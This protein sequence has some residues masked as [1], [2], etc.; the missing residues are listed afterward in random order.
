VLQA[1][2]AAAVAALPPSQRVVVELAY[3][4]GYTHAEIAALVKQPLGTVKTRIRRGMLK[5]L[6]AR[7]G[8]DTSTRSTE[9][10]FTVSLSHV[11][12]DPVKARSLAVLDGVRVLVVDDDRDT[13]EMVTTVLE[14]AG[15]SVM[16]D[17]S[18]PAALDRMAAVWP[19][20]LLADLA[21]PGQDGFDLVRK[22]KALAGQHRR[23][24]AGAF[25]ALTAERDRQAARSAGYDLY[26]TK[27]I[28]P[29]A[30]VRAVRSLVTG[31]PNA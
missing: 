17:R 6:D 22:A 21:M 24:R 26:L 18:A 5:L 27:P 9:R 20:V 14:S 30:I 29:D 28:Q 1:W 10:P 12:A 31:S 16:Q 11:L 4:G 15:A 2:A 19:D 23:L 8:F 13:L 7:A 25:T 3:F